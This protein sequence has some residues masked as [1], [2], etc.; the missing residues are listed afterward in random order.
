MTHCI[1]LHVPR[2]SLR[3]AGIIMTTCMQLNYPSVTYFDWEGCSVSNSVY[4]WVAGLQLVVHLPIVGS[5]SETVHGLRLSIFSLQEGSKKL[6]IL[7]QKVARTHLQESSLLN[8]DCNSPLTKLRSTRERAIQ[9]V[10]QVRQLEKL[11]PTT[12]SDAQ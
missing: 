5:T 11:E 9:C 3:C 6:T 1:L 4:A 10:S 12:A 8:S 7:I 2:N